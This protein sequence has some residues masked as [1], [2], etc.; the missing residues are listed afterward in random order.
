MILAVQRY[1]RS[2]PAFAVYI[3]FSIA[4]TIAGLAARNNATEYSR[5]YWVSETFYVLLAFLVLLEVFKSVFSN[6]YRLRWFR[7]LFPCVGLLM[8]CIAIIRVL[9]KPPTQV[10]RA[11]VVIIF[12]ELAVRFLQI[13]I[14]FLFFALVRF[15]HMHWRRHEFGIVLGFAISAAGNLAA[16]LL[17]S[18]FGTKMNH[19]VRMTPPIAYTVAVV[20][21]LLTFLIPP[22]DNRLL[23]QASELTPEE[24]L[25]E[26]RQYRS[27]VKKILKR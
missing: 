1:Y 12:L 25:A 18:E 20:V 13:G 14:F 17:R 27:S 2:F 8:I 24:M 9:A 10:N 23:S 21:W 4:S 16:F 26:V 11:Y 22:P 6:F 5:M 7:L 3:G 19:F 15:F